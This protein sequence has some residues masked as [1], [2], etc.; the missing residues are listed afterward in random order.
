MDKDSDS[1][2]GGNCAVKSVDAWWYNSCH[3]STL[4]G[5]YMSAGKQG[6][7]GMVWYYWKNNLQALKGSQMML[8]PKS[9]E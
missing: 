3:D 8:R 4:N 1:N 6:S 5:Q 2:R 7:K 9:F